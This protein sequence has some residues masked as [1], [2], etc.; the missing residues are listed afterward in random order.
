MQRSDSISELAKALAIAQGKIGAAKKD[1]DN[2]FFKSKYADL[3][4]VVDAIREPLSTAGL[5]WV[6][7]TVPVDHAVCVETVLMHASGEWISSTTTIPVDKSNAQAFG[8]ALTYARRYGLMS[9]VG[10]APDDDDGNAAAAASPP[11]QV[12]VPINENNAAEA[13]QVQAAIARWKPFLGSIQTP[14]AATRAIEEINQDL[15]GEPAKAVK[16]LL[17][18]VCEIRGYAFDKESKE[19]KETANAYS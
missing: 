5:A 9:L 3:A 18:E 7:P 1:S 8:S 17:L 15:A 10:V 2:P 13:A 12:G 19:F 11:K 14:I 4:S 16:R 6:Q